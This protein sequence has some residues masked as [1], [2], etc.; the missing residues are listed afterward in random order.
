MNDQAADIGELIEPAP[1]GFSFDA[2]GWYGLGIALVITLIIVALFAWRRHVRNRYRRS[3][4]KY[5]VELEGSFKDQ[6]LTYEVNMLMKRIAL[7]FCEREQVAALRG[8]EWITFL[9]T[10]GRSELFSSETRKV[11]NSLYE[12][13]NENI[14]T[15]EFV[16]SARQWIKVHEFSRG[17]KV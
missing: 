1:V 17:K 13:G 3:A 11:L 8:K 7:R 2:P 15:G 5:M 6:Q 14:S 16:A 12:G 4:L 10:S 9:N